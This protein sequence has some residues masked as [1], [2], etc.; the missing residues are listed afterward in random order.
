MLQNI[1]YNRVEII[2]LGS[3][4]RDTPF[5]RRHGLPPAARNDDPRA[6]TRRGARAAGPPSGD[7]AADPLPGPVGA[8]LGRRRGAGRGRHPFH[9]TPARP[10]AGAPGERALRPVVWLTGDPVRPGAL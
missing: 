10:G 9:A 2:Q 8:R 7:R 6:A 1:L 4:A 5:G 3:L